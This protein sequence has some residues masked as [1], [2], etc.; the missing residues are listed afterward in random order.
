M[1]FN[2]G[3]KGLNKSIAFTIFSVVLR[4][5]ASYDLL[6]H[7][8]SRSHTTMH[9]IWQDFS[10]RVIIPTHRPLPDNT[11][12]SHETDIHAT[13][14]IR[15]HDLSRRVAA[16]L[17]LRQRGHCERLYKHILSLIQSLRLVWV[18]H[19]IVQP[20]C[21]DSKEFRLVFTFTLYFYY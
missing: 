3:F 14:E 12:H 18:R 11:Q 13:G 9:H 15:T 4:P 19:C 1:G 10:G 2:S 8:V 16:N 5:I 20:C 7:K 21:L 6:I 17:R